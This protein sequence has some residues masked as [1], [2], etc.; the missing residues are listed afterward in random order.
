VNRY[1]QDVLGQPTALRAAVSD[2]GLTAARW[3]QEW[4]ESGR[5]PIVFTGMGASLFAAEAVSAVLSRDGIRSRAIATSDLLDYE[6]AALADDPFLVV[7]SQSGESAELAGLMERVAPDRVRAVTNRAEGRLAEWAGD[8]LVMGASP[9]LSVAI[10][11]YT[12]TLAVLLLFASALRTGVEVAVARILAAADE[13]ERATDA[14]QS[15]ARSIATRLSGVQFVTYLGWASGIASAREASLLMKEGARVASEAMSAAQFRHGAVEVVDRRQAIV[16]FMNDRG[17]AQRED[18]WAYVA[19]LVALDTTVV[20]IGPEPPSDVRSPRLLHVRAGDTL[21]EAASIAEIV[22][23]Q[24]LAAELAQSAGFEAGGFRNTTP[25][26][27]RIPV[28]TGG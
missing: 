3:A 7:V 5:R 19:E 24:L 28:R 13:I 18:A 26:V 8:S 1:L 20:V 12:V 6:L 22:P 27:S 23:I 21:E 11:S 17:D 25:V 9:D 10:R 14:W 4:H 16:F 2:S 15:A